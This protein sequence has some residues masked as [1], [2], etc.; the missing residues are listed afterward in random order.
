[1]NPFIAFCLYV[2]ARIYVQTYKKRPEDRQTQSNLEF[3]LDAMQAIK[4]K[5]PLTESFL[6]QLMVDLEGTS[7][8]TPSNNAR[9][10]IS[11]KD[12]CVGRILPVAPCGHQNLILTLYRFARLRN[13]VLLLFSG[14][15]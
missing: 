3:I 4:K 1:M 9:I 2:A 14:T 15:K 13:K 11:V 6:A 7:F 10:S 12:F 8:D 5:N